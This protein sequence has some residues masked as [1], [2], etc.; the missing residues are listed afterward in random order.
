MNREVKISTGYDYGV[1]IVKKEIIPCVFCN[2]IFSLNCVLK[3]YF[4][5]ML[6][7]TCTP[8]AEACERE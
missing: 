6:R 4:F 8:L 1:Q 2:L 5:V 3:D 7:A